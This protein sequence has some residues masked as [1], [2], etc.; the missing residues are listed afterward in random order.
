VSIAL[1]LAHA[2]KA[3]LGMLYVETL[4]CELPL[5]ERGAML[6]IIVK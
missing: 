4:V 5:E 2:H 1:S 3:D 6:F